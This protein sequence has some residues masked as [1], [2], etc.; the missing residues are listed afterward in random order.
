MLTQRNFIQHG[1]AFVTHLLLLACLCFPNFLTMSRYYLQSEGLGVYFCYKLSPKQLRSFLNMF[2]EH[3]KRCINSYIQRLAQGKN[4]LRRWTSLTQNKSGKSWLL[5]T[6]WGKGS[7]GFTT[8]N[9]THFK[10]AVAFPCKPSFRATRPSQSQPAA[11]RAS[12]S[13]KIAS[14]VMMGQ[15][16]FQLRYG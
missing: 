10:Q 5:T 6:W 15:L 2:W 11:S 9:L 13:N 16:P 12:T 4:R 7:W 8:F 1:H 3:Q 14:Y